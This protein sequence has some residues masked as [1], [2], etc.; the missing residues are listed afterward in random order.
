MKLLNSIVLAIV[1][2]LFLS[3]DADGQRKANV[4]YS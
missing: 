2:F 1:A 3:G 4:S